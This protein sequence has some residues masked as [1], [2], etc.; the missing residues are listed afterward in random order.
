MERIF[1]ITLL[2]VFLASCSSQEPGAQC[3]ESFKATLKDPESGKVIEFEN[4]ILTYT[5]TNSYGA[6][7]QG[8]AICTNVGE[9]WV[10]NTD[11]EDIKVLN[12]V[13]LALEGVNSCRA[14]GG[15]AMSCAGNSLAFQSAA[16]SMS[17]VDIDRLSREVRSQLGFE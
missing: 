14:A 2:C 5:A 1:S 12:G 3:L 13:A 17:P 7:R 9:K 15:A 4:S 11:A 10:R 6:R 8:K 16:R